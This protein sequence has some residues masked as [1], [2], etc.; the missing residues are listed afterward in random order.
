LDCLNR[1][2]LTIGTTNFIANGKFTGGCPLPISPQEGML[3]CGGQV[4]AAD[5]QI[6][7]HFMHIGVGIGD[8]VVVGDWTAPTET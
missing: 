8:G 3:W 4:F 1:T 6:D 2:V 5:G 7:Q